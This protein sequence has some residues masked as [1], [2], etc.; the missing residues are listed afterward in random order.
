[1]QRTYLQIELRIRLVE[2]RGRRKLPHLPPL[3]MQHYLDIASK[4][5]EEEKWVQNP[6]TRNRDLHQLR[7]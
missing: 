1:M 7:Q 5:A 4:A 6:S 2:D 3:A